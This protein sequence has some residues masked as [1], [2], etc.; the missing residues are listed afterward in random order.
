MKS[1]RHCHRYCEDCD[2]IYKINATTWCYDKK[3]NL[4]KLAEGN[5][6]KGGK[7]VLSFNSKPEELFDIIS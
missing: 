6:R 1:Y 5:E 7:R 3:Y 4:P 2:E